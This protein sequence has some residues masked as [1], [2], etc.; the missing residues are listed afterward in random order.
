[1]ARNPNMFTKESLKGLHEVM[2]RL[3]KEVQAIKDRSMVGLIKFAVLV[4]RDMDITPPLIPI[5]SG[6]LRASRFILTGEKV[7][8]GG[9]PQFEGKEAGN[10]S[11]D[12]SSSL[13]SSTA[14]ATGKPVVVMGF[15]ANYAVAVHEMV[16]GNFTGPQEKIKYTKKG[17]VMQST[18]KYLRRAGA[19]AKFLEESLKRNEKE[20]LMIIAENAKINE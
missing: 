19:G 2:A 7:V 6:N 8:E 9:A 1:M 4:S 13:S 15:S 3:N 12:H 11:S 5:D 20:G 17:K 18:R 16:G 14:L 10:M